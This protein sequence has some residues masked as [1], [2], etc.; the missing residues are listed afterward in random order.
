VLPEIRD[1]FSER[2]LGKCALLKRPLVNLLHHGT[3]ALLP[4]R[5]AHVGGLVFDFTLDS[6][7]LCDERE[8]FFTWPRRTLFDLDK[9]AWVPEESRRDAIGGNQRADVD[10]PFA[11]P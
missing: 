6:T 7:K 11:L 10:P 9:L 3:C 1:H 5:K 4:N 8:R 2:A